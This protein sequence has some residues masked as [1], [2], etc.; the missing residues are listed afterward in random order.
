MEVAESYCWRYFFLVSNFNI[1]LMYGYERIK[2]KTFYR[3]HYEQLIFFSSETHDILFKDS[4][5]IFQMSKF[6]KA[7]RSCRKM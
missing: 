2:S 3:A 5:D 7:P 6:L 1:A 4:F